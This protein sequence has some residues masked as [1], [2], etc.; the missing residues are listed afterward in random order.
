M[1]NE[2]KKIILGSITGLFSTTLGLVGALAWNDAIKDI[3][4][5]ALGGGE[6]N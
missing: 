5:R 2:T 3:I 1:V 6:D 4:K